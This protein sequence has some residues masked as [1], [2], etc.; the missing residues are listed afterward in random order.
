[1]VELSVN[2]VISLRQLGV[3]FSLPPFWLRVGVRQFLLLFF[4]STVCL[5]FFFLVDLLIRLYFLNFLITLSFV[6]LGLLVLSFYPVKI[7]PNSVPGL[8]Y[9]S[10]WVIDARERQHGGR[11]KGDGKQDHNSDNLSE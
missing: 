7:G 1:M 3:S 5:P 10:F 11:H 9:M 6:C 8:S 2:T 4:F